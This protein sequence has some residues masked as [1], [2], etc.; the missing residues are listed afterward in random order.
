MLNSKDLGNDERLVLSL[1]RLGRDESD[2][3]KSSSE[4]ENS[5]RANR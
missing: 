2:D 1:L 4:C 3:E 5:K